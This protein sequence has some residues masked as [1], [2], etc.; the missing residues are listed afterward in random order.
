[1]QEPWSEG[2]LDGQ[3]TGEDKV[4]LKHFDFAGSVWKSDTTT[5]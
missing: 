3:S 4:S 1:L 5:P 2:S